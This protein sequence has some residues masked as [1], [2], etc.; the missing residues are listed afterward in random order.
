MS[1]KLDKLLAKIDPSR[2]YDAVSARV[3]QAFNSFAMPRSIITSYGEYEN[4]LA[5]FYRHT[6]TAALRIGAGVPVDRKFFWVRCSKL[7]KKGYGPDGYHAVY[8]ILKT[9]KEGG[10]YS[11]LK[12]IANLMIEEYAQNQITYEIYN[13]W[14]N[15]T[16][17]ER[18]AAPDEYLSKYGY[19]LPNDM[20][21]GNAPRIK[22]FFVKV[23]KE[24]PKL[25][26]RMRRIG[27]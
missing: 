14:E 27:R 18:L 25:I 1:T 11:V 15:L 6:E 20:T 2:T 10:L 21:E 22:A 3:D 13:Y 8:T 19:L 12:K 9:G 7:I 4:V 5:D 16:T 24:H 17:E 26:M 23:L